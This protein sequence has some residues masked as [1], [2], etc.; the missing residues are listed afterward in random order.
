MRCLAESLVKTL[1]SQEILVTSV[2]NLKLNSK[3]RQQ[4]NAF[5]GKYFLQ[6]KLVYVLNSIKTLLLQTSDQT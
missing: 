1:L 6:Y 3:F 4:F 2:G 5:P